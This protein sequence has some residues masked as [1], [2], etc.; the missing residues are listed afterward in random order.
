MNIWLI[1]FGMAVV[2][3]S[4]RF[5]PLTV[6]KAESLPFW[7]QRGLNYVPIAVLSA[8]I[9]PALLPSEEWFKFTLDAHFLAGI[10]AIAAAWWTRSTLITLAVGMA[11]LI[12]LG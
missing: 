11:V 9:G 2:T 12:A 5:L 8:I 7:A 10:A 1:I 3:Y 6:I 4:I